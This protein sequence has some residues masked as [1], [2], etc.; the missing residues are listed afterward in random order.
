MPV[1]DFRCTSCDARTEHVVLQG[2]EVPAVCS[3]CGGALKR[4][5]GGARV[6]VALQ[7]WGFSKTDSLISDTRGKDFKALKERADR[8]RDE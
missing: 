7:G 6:H 2:E 4:V 8:I 5:Y 3:D 1:F